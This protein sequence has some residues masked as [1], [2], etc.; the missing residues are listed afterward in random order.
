M[1]GHE[2]ER[3]EGYQELTLEEFTKPK[4][5]PFKPGDYK[6]FRLQA[7]IDQDEVPVES[8]C[9]DDT[10]AMQ[11]AFLAQAKDVKVRSLAAQKQIVIKNK[12]SQKISHN[13]RVSDD[14]LP[15]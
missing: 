1:Y 14:R 13:L 4:K 6:A 9:V 2:D 5:K 11:R 8:I 7:P 12:E 15:E 3:E 10:E